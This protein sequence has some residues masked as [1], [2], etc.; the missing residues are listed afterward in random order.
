MY[1]EVYIF[2]AMMKRYSIAEA[3][4]NLPTIV[5]Q[6]EAGQEIELTRR[7][8]PVAVVVSLRELERLRG[9]RVPF[10]EAYRRFLKMH[11]LREL[12][13]DDDLFE[14]ARDRDPGRKVSL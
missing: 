2:A 9:E 13:V 10:G 1:I 7:G 5:D 11:P 8:K 3:R 6:A 14:A 12:G 4:A